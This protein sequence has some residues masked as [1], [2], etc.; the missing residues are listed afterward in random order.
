M[1][2]RSKKVKKHTTLTRRE[3]AK[4]SIVLGS[5]AGV[6]P[7]LSF[8]NAR[9]EQDNSTWFDKPMRWSQLTLVENDPGQY[10]PDFW[11]D[12]FKRTHSDAL[13]LSAGGVVAY[14]P[15][16]IEFHHRSLWMGDSDP[17]GYLLKQC[18]EMD[19]VVIA[20]TDPHAIW[21]DA[22]SAHPEWA[23][24]DREGN[25]RKHWSKPDLYVTCALG[26]YNFE[27]M[28]EVHREI[29][30]RYALDGIFSNR[31]A[32]HGICYCESCQKNFQDFSR[33]K[34][35]Q[36]TQRLDPG[37]QKWK[38]WRM[39]RLYNLWQLWD[40]EI[41]N[42]NPQARFIPNGFPDK[43]IAGE[44]SDILFTDHQARNGLTLPWDNGKRAKEYRAI[45]GKKPIGGIFSVGVEERY[46]WKDSVQSE[47]E[48][49]IWVANG[50]ANG[51]RPWYTK[52]SGTLYDHRW[53]SFVEDIYKWHHKAEKYLRNEKPLATVAMVYSE[54]TQRFYGGEKYQDNADD[55]NKGMYHALIE[56]RVPFEMVNEHYLDA[57][58]IDHF[59]L[60]ILP[61]I[62]ALSESQCQ[63]IK[64]YVDRGGSIIATFET[65]LYNENGEKRNDF[66]LN[67]LLGVSFNGEVEGPMKNSYL[68]LAKEN[69]HFHPILKDLD[70]TT[71]IINGVHRLGIQPNRE[72]PSPV[73]L[74]PSYP[75]LPMEH[76][77][78]LEPETDIR[79]VYLRDT[80]ESRIVYFPWDID[81]TFWQI[82]S[83]DHGM[84]IRNAVRWAMN[85]EQP[86]T[87]TG[88]GILDITIWEQ[89]Q[90]ITAH[91]VNL[92]NPMMM[93]GPY[94]ELIPLSEQE[95]KIQVPA[96]KKVLGVNLLVSGIT[97]EYKV[98]DGNVELLVSNILDHEVIAL[99][100]GWN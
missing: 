88:P 68:R 70:N 36:S 86:V 25:A 19:M 81:R 45:M 52:F 92:T 48:V 61:N 94:R 20:R 33:M 7:H 14:Y 21:P 12:Y 64:N 2:S 4:T 44:Q 60:L 40:S 67:D 74:I 99:D 31:W 58:H 9:V 35:P 51:M 22:Y 3:F 30:E 32:G 49:R 97:P 28:T 56:A 59:K 83:V 50:T 78:P 93:K 5:M 46:R 34:L 75:D 11:L 85:E 55:H 39:K 100:L 8:M 13:C 62:A 72:F 69:G 95:V 77:Y 98:I 18:R 42:V 17:F 63:Q 1:G 24:I 23:A 91:L 76:V 27:F 80:G 96:G 87:V 26:P 54:Q 89:K 84:L 29:M 6:A 66:G 82:L 38:E 15:T 37:Y 57:Q 43:K 16:E 73:T 53:L 90:S 47:A 79:E 41:R 10:D 65:S 71:R